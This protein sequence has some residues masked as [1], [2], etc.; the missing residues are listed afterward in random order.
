MKLFDHVNS[1]YMQT[2]QCKEKVLETDG[3]NGVDRI[4]LEILANALFGSESLKISET[5]GSCDWNVLLKE[6]QLQGVYAL[7]FDYL[8]EILQEELETKKYN[9][10]SS[11]YYRIISHNTNNAYYHRKIHVLL[12][13]KEI[14]YVIIK[15][16]VSGSYYPNPKLRTSGDIDFLVS[17]ENLEC[18]GDI[19]EQLGFKKT[20]DKEHDFHIAY[21]N[22]SQT[23][24]MHWKVG[25]IPASKVGDICKRYFDN[26]FE[27]EKIY[28]GMMVPDDFHHGLVLLL[29]TARHILN[30]GIGIKHL[31]DWAVYASKV[32]VSE[33]EQQLR[34]VG[35]WRFAQL[36]TQVS[37]CFL[38]CPQREWAMEN[39]DKD[40][41]NDILEDFFVAGEFGVKSPERI[42]EAK[43][44]TTNAQGNV[45]DNS[46]IQLFRMLTEKAKKALPICNQIWL[47]IPV[48]WI[49]V[50][51]RHLIRIDQ[52]R[53]PP[54]HVRHMIEGADKRR[55]VYKKFGLFQ[56]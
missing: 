45:G 4:L 6:A 55:E 20:N 34:D 49:Y 33:Y 23:I 11:Q 50:G 27:T 52:G 47:L 18:T 37:T 41:L 8:K 24:E 29:H 3:M 2:N 54:V 22:G 13:Q 32:D 15:G 5:N 19:L 7:V 14:P 46:F 38:G 17:K 48:G 25:G 40:L 44:M 10:Y 36:L 21:Y 35:L 43:L 28:D 53:R 56:V 51:I 39:V 26:I 31:C 16:Q 30:T 9:E 12:S 42:N 1:V